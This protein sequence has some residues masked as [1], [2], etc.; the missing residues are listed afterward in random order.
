MVRPFAAM[1]SL[2]DLAAWIDEPA[3]PAYRLAFG[4]DAASINRGSP[5]T[6]RPATSYKEGSV[7][8]NALAANDRSVAGGGPCLAAASPTMALS[9][10]MH[11]PLTTGL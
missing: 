5:L 8:P 3:R 4:Q 1:V 6:P 11:P 7:S 9:A 2:I 10:Q